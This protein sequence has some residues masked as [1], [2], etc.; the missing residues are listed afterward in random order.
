MT[1][2]IVSVAFLAAVT[3]CVPADTMMSTLSRTSSAAKVGQ[4]VEPD[5]PHIDSR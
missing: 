5:P 3:P 2:G 1:M 4:P